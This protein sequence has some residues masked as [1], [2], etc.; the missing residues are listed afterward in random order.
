MGAPDSPVRHRTVT[1][2]CPVR[3]TSPQ[4]LGFEAVDRCRRL[5]SC[6]TDSLVTSNFCTLTSVVAMFTTVA[7]HS[8]P[9]ARREP[10]LHWLTGRYGGTPDSPVNYSEGCPWNSREWLVWRVPSL[11]H[12]TLSGA[13]KTAHSRFCSSF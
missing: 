3:A 10:L 2:H 1:V 12:R 5:L 6:C 9:L 7:L 4:P 13:P 8:R 11:V